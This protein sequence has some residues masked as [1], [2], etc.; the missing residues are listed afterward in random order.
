MKGSKFLKVSLFLLLGT[1]YLSP[2][3]STEI[4]SQVF[5]FDSQILPAAFG[6]FNSDELTDLFVLRD[7]STTVEILLGSNEATPLLKAANLKCTLK[8]CSITSVVPGDFNGDALMDVLLTVKCPGTQSINLDVHILWGVQNSLN[9][10]INEKIPILTMKGEA[11]AIDSNNDFIIDLFGVHGNGTWGTWFFN[12]NSHPVFEEFAIPKHYK[13]R[14]PHSNAYLDLNND[15]TA[16]LF[17]T[18]QSQDKYIFEEYRG[19]R[20]SSK[21]SYYSQYSAPTQAKRKLGQSI[22]LDLELKG[23]MN[24]LVPILDKTNPKIMV[25]D[26]TGWR[27]LNVDFKKDEKTWYFLES[28]LPF[29]KTV[30][31]RGGDYNMD[32]YPDLLATLTCGAINRTFLLENVPCHSGCDNFTRTFQIQWDGFTKDLNDSV[33]GVFYD[34]FQNGILDVILIRQYQNGTY[35]V[36]AIKNNLDYDANFIKVMVLTGLTNKNVTRTRMGARKNAFGTNLPGPRVA[37]RTVDQDGFLRTGVSAQI[38]Q[39]AHYALNLPYIMFA[40]GRTPNFVDNITVGFASQERDLLQVIPN[41]QMVVIPNQI[42]NPSRWKV[43][44]FVTPS[45]IIV[46][47]GMALVGTCFVI[48]LIIL[49]LHWKEKKL[50]K[51]E[52]LQ[53]AHRFNFDAM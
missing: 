1:S 37:Y 39:S 48:I 33:D 26:R 17:L 5:G 2:S 9:C 50:D 49:Y 32:G 44:L 53:E 52:R 15:N 10:T 25:G 41:S 30:N 51:L 34:I 42:D 19:Q 40:L 23:K 14:D 27:N 7:N 20:K 11:L 4:T 31:L 35:H 6:D 28:G 13:M 3:I 29:S 38:P 22:F 36:S 16:D 18:V 21:F 12:N 43:Q 46:L 24:H 8:S 45:K 47:S